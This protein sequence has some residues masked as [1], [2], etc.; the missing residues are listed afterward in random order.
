[1]M[2]SHSTDACPDNV[3]RHRIFFKRPKAVPPFDTAF[4]RASDT[5]SLKLLLKAAPEHCQII[6]FTDGT[7]AAYALQRLYKRNYRLNSQAL[8]LDL[9][10]I[11]FTGQIVMQFV[12]G[13]S[14]REPLARY[15]CAGESYIHEA[16]Q[17]NGESDTLDMFC[18]GVGFHEVMRRRGRGRSI[19][20][21][22]EQ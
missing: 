12:K 7:G 3:R 6:L 5:A 21:A 14:M 18:C 13:G 10:T 19:V 15:F 1:M 2:E 11:T 9:R 4:V 22:E 16:S 20:F 17:T 8:Q